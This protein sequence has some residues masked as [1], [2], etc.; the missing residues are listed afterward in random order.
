MPD[1]SDH[2]KVQVILRK[3][4][5][6]AKNYITAVSKSFKTAESGY[7]SAKLAQ[8]LSETLRGPRDECPD[9]VIQ[10]SIA[11]MQEIAQKASADATVTAGMFDANFQEFTQVRRSHT[12]EVRNKTTSVDPSRGFK[13]FQRYRG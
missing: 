6:G 8:E 9:E 5:K 3:I 13:H 2:P 7:A 10:D 11:E 1:R 12:D 4:Y